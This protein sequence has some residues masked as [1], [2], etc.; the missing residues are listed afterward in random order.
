MF[1]DQAMQR[2]VAGKTAAAVPEARVDSGPGFAR[3]ALDGAR[4]HLRPV[5]VA[6]GVGIGPF[7]DLTGGEVRQIDAA[8]HPPMLGEQPVQGR[9][10]GKAAAAGTEGRL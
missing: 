8:A 5:A 7:E 9:A 2:G 6:G 4:A 10:A 1:A 3:S